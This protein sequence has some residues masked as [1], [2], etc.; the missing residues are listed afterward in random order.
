MDEEAVDERVTLRV[1]E[2]VQ[3]SQRQLLQEM[4]SL[5]QKISDQNSNSNEQQL[6]KISNIVATGEAPKFKRK[7]NEEQYKLNSKVMLKL[8]EAVQAAE[9]NTAK[10]KESIIESYQQLF[11]R[12][13]GAMPLR[14]CPNVLFTGLR[15]YI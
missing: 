5:F 12:F 3:E 4:N 15:Q 10:T 6:L 8:D 11:F 14:N 13:L 9:S 2:A 7:S 1:R